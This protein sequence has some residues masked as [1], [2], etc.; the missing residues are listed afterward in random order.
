[1]R[2]PSYQVHRNP[3]RCIDCQVCVR[4]CTYGVHAWDEDFQAVVADDAKCV[5]C[6][7]CVVFCPTGALAVTPAPHTFVPNANWR[8]D[9]LREVYLQAETGGTLLVGMGNDR[10]YKIFW[11]HLLLNA[12][13][14]TNPS[15][16]PLRE[17]VEVKTL[18]GRKPDALHLSGGGLQEPLPPELELEV[19]I[20]FS[21]MS[22]GSVSLNTQKSLARAAVEEGTYWN[23]GEGGLHPDVLPYAHR[24]IVQVASGR[25]GVSV[26]YLNAGAAVEI[27]IGQGAKPGIGGH[28]PG[29]KVG[30]EVS[31]T[32]MIPLGSDAISPAPH[33]DIYSIEDLRQLINS[34]KEAT[35]HRKPVGVKI[36]A[37]HNVAAIASGSVRAG[38]DFL[39]IDGF[40]GGTGAAP[41]RIRDNVGIPIEL[42]LAAV[43]S[44]LREEGIRN[45][46]SL[47]VSGGIR[48][49]ADV[50]KA[51]AL[52]ADAVNIATAALIALGCHMC[53]MCYRGRCTWGIATTDAAL[54][55]RV[56][57][58]IGARR[59]ANL[60]R[61]WKH[62]IKEM[63]GGMG[64][65]AI[66]S[67]RGNRLALRGIGLS[68]REL[69]IL[70]V[71]AAGE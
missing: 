1:M 65:N 69:R 64:I 54:T 25:F 34:L 19:P 8:S 5:N 46:A 22:F 4:Q 56:N 39:V 55:K 70:G 13:Q 48:N 32:R 23:C 61:A 42:A 7:R 10:P 11:D 52:G 27:K 12:S 49:S 3:Q 17:P 71:S 33:H 6:H 16:D 57:P 41:L 47:V 37:V 51:I 63:L 38:A 59:A 50:I 26:D 30:D 9:D 53:Q 60:L 43:D 14:V 40:R 20:M 58:D 15:I 21:A 45:H 28:L 18:L 29:E 66:E 35:Q 68:E 31:R 62:E 44:R 36:A 24:A 67:L 2:V